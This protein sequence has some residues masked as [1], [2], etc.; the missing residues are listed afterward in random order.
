MSDEAVCYM[1]R[2]EGPDHLY[3]TC[4]ALARVK[5]WSVGKANRDQWPRT[6]VDLV[7]PEGT[8]LCGWCVR[9]WKA[10]SKVVKPS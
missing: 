4:P 9:V 10:R 7:D 6:T 3:S 8:D 5:P 1:G 2:M